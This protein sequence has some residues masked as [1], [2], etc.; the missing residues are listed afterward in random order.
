MKEIA[1]YICIC[2]EWK[3]RQY[4]PIHFDMPLGQVIAKFFV[5]IVQTLIL[6]LKHIAQAEI[7]NSKANCA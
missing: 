4:I 5:T 7:D 6:T 1:P 2:I 3:F